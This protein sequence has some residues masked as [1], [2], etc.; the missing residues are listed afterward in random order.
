MRSEYQSDK[1]ISVCTSLIYSFYLVPFSV[2]SD[3]SWSLSPQWKWTLSSTYSTGPEYVSLT[4]RRISL[5]ELLSYG[6]GINV[7]IS[8]RG[9]EVGHIRGLVSACRL[10]SSYV[11]CTWTIKVMKFRRNRDSDCETKAENRGNVRRNY[12]Y[13]ICDKTQH[14]MQVKTLP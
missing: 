10:P 7:E 12:V 14:G 13:L 3:P 8:D 5:R 1:T 4:T 6:L 11:H 9:W 2:C